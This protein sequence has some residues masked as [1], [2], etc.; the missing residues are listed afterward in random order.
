MVVRIAPLRPQIGFAHRGAK[1]HARENTLEAFR[2]AVRLGANGLESDVWMTSDGVPVLDHD[3]V[4]GRFP[5]RRQISEV[6]RADLPDHIPSLAELYDEVGTDL[7]I[8]LDAK[9]VNSGAGVVDVA[10]NAGG[11]A[12]GKL[13]FCHDD[14]ELLGVWRHLSDDIKLVDSTRG[15]RIKEGHERRAADL[16]AAGIDA[17]NLHE[18]DWKAGMVATYHRFERYALG[19]DA[20]ASRIIDTLIIM[21]LDGVFSD[22]SDRLHDSLERLAQPPG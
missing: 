7:E 19:W 11:D 20:Q 14:H 3:G 10:R 4:V 21:G 13:W 16:Q 18:S 8:S 22:H 5:R 6:A 1:A 2:L 17:V 12:L 15:R 9:D